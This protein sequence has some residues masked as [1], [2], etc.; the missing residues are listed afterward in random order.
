MAQ[1]SPDQQVV[2]GRVIKPHGIRGELVVEPLSDLPERFAV[3]AE[4]ELAGRPVVIAACRPHQGR[5]LLRIDGV[6][7]RTAAEQ[8]RGHELTAPPVDLDG[9][10]TYFVHELV[11]L[12]VVAEDGDALGHVEAVIELPDSAGYDL[13][14]VRREDGRRWL[15]PA[16]DDYVEVE[17]DPDGTT[18]LVV[19]DPPEGLVEPAAAASE[20]TAPA[21]DADG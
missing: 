3:G 6:P 2:I 12:A 19:V 8:L 21:Q 5:L 20:P 1:P 13:L 4:L 17:Q 9:S 15:L 14:E 16:V 18:W 10:A 11:G 7:D